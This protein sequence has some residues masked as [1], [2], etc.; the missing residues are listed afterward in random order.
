MT[1][2]FIAALLLAA[3]SFSANVATIDR[4]S[5]QIIGWDDSCGVAVAKLSYPRMGEALTTEPFSTR[6]GL[7]T[8]EPQREKGELRWTLEL[9]GPAS[10]DERAHQSAVEELKRNG[11]TRAGYSE[12]IL[13]APVGKQPLLAETLFS[14]RTFQSKLISGWP[15]SDWRLAEAHFNPL[16]TCVLLMY[17]NRRAAR[18][19]DFILTHTY[20]PRVRIE[21]AYAHVSNA[22]LLFND[23]NLDTAAREAAT[24]AALAPELGIGRYEHAAMLALTGH[25][26]EAMRELTA[27]IKLDRKYAN[28]AREDIDF[29][30]LRSREDFKEATR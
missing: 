19:Y 9:D 6:V 22:R 14:T 10:W 23:G 20:N 27:A 13:N 24:A 29:H 26:D 5:W 21:R 28:K 12:T 1:T 7:V 11:L 25:D 15:S 8:L 30:D 16:T 2:F 17:E 4:E 18:Q 3:P